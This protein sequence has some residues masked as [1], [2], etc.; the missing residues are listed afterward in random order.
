MARWRW[1]V[2]T[3]Y[4]IAWTIALLFPIQPRTGE[5]HIDEAI[6][7]F[8]YAVAKTVHVGAY[9]VMTILTGWLN[10]P[11]RYRFMLVFFLMVHGTLTEL[12]QFGM[13]Q[14]QI[15]ERNGDLPDVGFDNLGIL[16]GLY[17]SRKWWMREP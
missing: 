11:I 14:L 3:I 17:V 9:A 2:W 4:V 15:S 6:L 1:H 16:L 5:H 7:P 8:R 12:G 10:V 13:R